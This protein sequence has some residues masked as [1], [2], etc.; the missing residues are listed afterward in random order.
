VP[1]VARR[2][3]KRPKL[4]IYLDN[5]TDDGVDKIQR[6]AQILVDV[7]V[8]NTNDSPAQFAHERV[9]GPV[10]CDATGCPV[11]V[12]IDF[13]NEIRGC[14]GEIRDIRSDW[15]LSAKLVERVAPQ[16]RP[17]Q[18]FRARHGAAQSLCKF[19]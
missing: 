9:S 17:Q 6:R 8:S 13:D 18:R 4:T 10:M 11:S 3:G 19:P 16:T 7:G 14:T 5:A 2:R 12:A 1:S 15:M